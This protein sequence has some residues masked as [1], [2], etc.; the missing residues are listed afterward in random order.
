[1]SV[2]F[3]FI[4]NAIK[5]ETE[6]ANPLWT[7]FNLS[8]N[9]AYILCPNALTSP[10]YTP[11]LDKIEHHCVTQYDHQW[12]PPEDCG[13]VVSHLHY[14]FPTAAILARLTADNKVPVLVLCDGILEFRNSFLNPNIAAGS[15]FMPV[16]GHKIACLGEAQARTIEHWGNPGR[17]EVVG[18][19]RLDDCLSQFQKK[20]LAKI[21][22]E[23]YSEPTD[24]SA[25]LKVLIATARQPGFT[26]DQ[27]QTVFQ[28]LSDLKAVLDTNPH[29]GG[30]KIEPIWRLTGDLQKRLGVTQNPA[31]VESNEIVD[32][33][34]R[35]DA[36][37]TTPSTMILESYLHRLPTAVLDYTCAP[38]F[39][40]P[41]FPIE[42]KSAIHRTLEELARP[43]M[44][45][46][47]FQETELRD[48]LQITDHASTRLVEL[49]KKMMKQSNQCSEENKTLR[50]ER[51]ILKNPGTVTETPP[52]RQVFEGHET[53]RPNQQ[54]VDQTL[55]D[56]T[57]RHITQLTDRVD[58][59]RYDLSTARHQARTAW[60]QNEHL[61]GH[62][63]WMRTEIQRLQ[64]SLRILNRPSR[65][66]R[67]TKVKA[68]VAFLR[69]HYFI[70][71]PQPQD[72]RL[73]L[74]YRLKPLFELAPVPKSA[75]IPPTIENFQK[76]PRQKPLI[77]IW[78]TPPTKA[79]I[80]K[81]KKESW[82]S[83]NRKRVLKVVRA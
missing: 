60:R 78:K 23:K 71:Q 4:Q 3:C 75:I 26:P 27:M 41:A 5:L 47:F 50:F 74:R 33:M 34:K 28:S 36:V 43:S 65:Q 10:I 1:M 42:S 72:S 56:Q 79:L 22:E 77:Q 57:L 12:M 6:F 49:M 16:H 39:V 64:L 54:E 68:S 13:L 18:L 37:I 48:Q 67:R 31:Q 20:G 53:F 63:K 55:F 82:R 51:N 19:P 17:P 44:A 58:E 25:P 38:K 62:I 73:S 40:S 76:N 11:W 15:V 45:K 69:W 80:R 61:E 59:L 9:T 24:E 29:I 70:S 32:L 52:L 35:V 30:R 7:T 21:Y 46:L 81:I 14:D 2:V 83:E 8:R 66:Q